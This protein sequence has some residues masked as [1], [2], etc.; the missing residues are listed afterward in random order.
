MFIWCIRSCT[1]G[2]LHIYIYIYIFQW[3]TTLLAHAWIYVY[4]HIQ[5]SVT[6]FIFY[7]WSSWTLLQRIINPQQSYIDIMWHTMKNSIYHDIWPPWKHFA[8]SWISIYSLIIATLSHICCTCTLNLLLMVKIVK[9]CAYM[10]K[11]CRSVSIV[12]YNVCAIDLSIEVERWD[13]L[14][15]LEETLHLMHRKHSNHLRALW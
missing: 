6:K 11:I 7:L 14:A 1:L 8:C 5:N 3:I 2:C 4:I 13:I 12:C 15:F 9:R 10:N